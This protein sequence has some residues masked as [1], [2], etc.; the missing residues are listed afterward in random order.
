VGHGCTPQKV[1]H[2]VWNPKELRATTS[3][4]N[5]L[6]LASGLSN[7]WLFAGRPR[8]QR[9]TQKLASPE[10]DFLSNR[11]S[12]KS[13]S[14]KPWSAKEE[15]EEYQRPKSG[16][17]RKYL[18]IRFTACQCEVLGDAWKRAHRHTENWMSGLVAVK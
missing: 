12:A 9:R 3:S 15:D 6:C 5:I 7:T 2:G 13:A 8:H 11:H 18:K 4:G 1:T 17:W 14:E 10:V 16:V